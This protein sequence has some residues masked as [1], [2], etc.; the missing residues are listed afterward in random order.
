MSTKKLTILSLYSAL[1]LIMFTIEAALPSILPIPGAKLGLANI[2]TLIIL[3]KYSAKDAF[4]VLIVRI[5]M[6][7][8]FT[9][10]AVM[11]I[12][13]ICGGLLSLIIM[14]FS[15]KFLDK[16]YIFITSILGGIF[17]NI[18][19]IFAAYFILKMSGILVYIP[20]LVIIGAITGF[21]IGL[22]TH[23]SKKILNPI[24]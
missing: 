8:I 23:F 4:I 12:Y 14:A 16:S 3:T 9:G 7:A 21:F 22:V 17:H 18:G 1:A 10:Q 2:I 11:L 13:S 19:Q 24:K 6:S 5:I 20:Y 15:N